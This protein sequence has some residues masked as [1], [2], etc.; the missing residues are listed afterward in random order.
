M[1]LLGRTWTRQKGEVSCFTIHL[2]KTMTSCQRQFPLN[3][4]IRLL[5]AV[6]V[7]PRTRLSLQHAPA[8]DFVE[9]HPKW[10]Q[11]PKIQEKC[12]KNSEEDEDHPEMG[13]LQRTLKQTVTN[14]LPLPGNTIPPSPQ[15]QHLPQEISTK[16]ELS[17]TATIP[18]QCLPPLQ[19]LL[20]EESRSLQRLT[21]EALKQ[22]ERKRRRG[23]CLSHLWTPAIL[24]TI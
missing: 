20:Q 24:Q 13:R 10:S 23:E 16:A 17:Q 14:L 11:N 2:M 19:A 6:D 7:N 9:R 21:V 18:A 12:L 4:P 3:L 15:T 8:A 1:R 22:A 5:L